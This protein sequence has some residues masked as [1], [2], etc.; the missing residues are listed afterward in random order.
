[1]TESSGET[2]RWDVLVVNEKADFQIAQGAAISLLRLMAARR[3]IGTGEEAVAEEWAEIYL[4]P[5]PSAHE[6]FATG[7]FEREAPVFQEAVLRFGGRPIPMP[8]GT[9]HDV[10]FFLEFRGCLYPE[11]LG[12]FRKQ[13]TELLHLRPRVVSRP[14]EP[15]PPHLEV[16]EDER[17]KEVAK[18]QRLSGGA[19]GTRVEEL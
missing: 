8:Y 1:M 18:R 15:P 17:P 16:P 3:W 14:S 2:K 11:P 12:P 4:Q 19:V 5:G 10:R 7:V 6:I 13:L 9:G